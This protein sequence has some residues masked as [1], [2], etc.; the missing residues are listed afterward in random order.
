MSLYQYKQRKEPL[1]QY[2]IPATPWIKIVTDIFTLNGADY[3]IV[4]EYTSN[5]PEI[6]KLRGTTSK[7]RL[8]A[9]ESIMARFGTPKIVF[10]DNAPQFSSAGFLSFAKFHNFQ[11]KTPSPEYA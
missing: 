11:S 1:H 9:L 5:F 6:V 2:D 7:D 4:V 10:S 8:G 3:L